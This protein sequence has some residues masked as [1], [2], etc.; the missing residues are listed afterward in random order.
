MFQMDKA[1]KSQGHTAIYL[2]PYHTE[3]NAIELI[4]S[5]LKV[6]VRR[7]NLQFKKVKVEELTQE[8]IESIDEN[9]WSSRYKHVMD[10]EKELWRRD[11][12]VEEEVDRVIIY[13]ASDC[14]VSIS[15]DTDT[16]SEG[17]ESTD[18]ADESKS[19]V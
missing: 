8:S 18:T 7:R 2:P 13:V 4:C 19:F 15:E 6:F 12:A 3:L 11:I 1:L 17:N 9:E 14:D 10:I 16:A 5:N